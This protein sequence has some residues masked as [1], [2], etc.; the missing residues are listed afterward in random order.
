MNLKPEF[1]DEAD[2]NFI[3]HVSQKTKTRVR[4]KTLQRSALY[5]GMNPDNDLPTYK[6][7]LI[8][9]FVGAMRGWLT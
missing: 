6:T 1:S 7:K 5:N 3:C 8:G 2:P 4:T 9:A